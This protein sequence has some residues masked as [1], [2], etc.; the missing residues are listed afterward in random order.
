[1]KK[2]SLFLVLTFFLSASFKGREINTTNKVEAIFNETFKNVKNLHWYVTNDTY[3]ARFASNDVIIS[4]TYDKDGKFIRSSRAGG[5]E[6][7]PVNILTKI[8]EK[9]RGKTIKLVTEIAEGAELLY[10]L[11][12][13]DEINSWIVEARPSGNNKVVSEFKKQRL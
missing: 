3:S 4:I 9:Y 11:T 10:S 2:L 8:K 12:I 6:L 5:E 13:E 1:M 7:L